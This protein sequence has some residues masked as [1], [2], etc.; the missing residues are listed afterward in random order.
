MVKVSLL[1]CEGPEA[2]G[3]CSILTPE[4][5]TRWLITLSL[6]LS[7]PPVSPLVFLAG[8]ISPFLYLSNTWIIITCCA[9]SL[10]LSTTILWYSRVLKPQLFWYGSF[11]GNNALCISGS[12]LL[13][14]VSLDVSLPAGSIDLFHATASAN[15]FLQKYAFLYPPR[16]GGGEG[17]AIVTK[18]L[19]RSKKK[20]IQIFIF[21]RRYIF[22]H[23]STVNS[24]FFKSH[25]ISL[26]RWKTTGALWN[27]S[28]IF[29]SQFISNISS[30]SALI[31]AVM[32]NIY[33]NNN[34]LNTQ[35]TTLINTQ[36]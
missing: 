14:R 33:T 32:D 24:A 10:F 36:S 35:I 18:A 1:E 26:N 19:S 15:G 9:N 22:L 16:N 29:I 7:I 30:S 3:T 21:T 12:V 20:K 5:L 4:V 34:I 8:W 23:L 6:L 2:E 17:R 31:V 11:R 25:L 13:T 28:S 27:G